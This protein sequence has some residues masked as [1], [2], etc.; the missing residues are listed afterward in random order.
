MLWT[1]SKRIDGVEGAVS[2]NSGQ[3]GYS[4]CNLNLH[5]ENRMSESELGEMLYN[6]Y[7]LMSDGAAIYFTLVTAYLATSYLVGSRLTTAQM[8]VVSSLYVV[9]SLGLINV[10][11]TQ[12][13]AVS[14]FQRELSA[15]GGSTLL[16]EQNTQVATWGFV[17]VQIAG[18]LASLYFMWSVRHPKTE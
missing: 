14:G 7:S 13:L 4:Y 1:G 15:M 8:L 9:W 3:W 10:Q 11:Y 12:I 18:M 5:G 16:I 2:P 17:G 6:A